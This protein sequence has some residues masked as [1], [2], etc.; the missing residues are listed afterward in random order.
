[1]RKNKAK[2]ADDEQTLRAL[3]LVAIQDESFESIRDNILEKPNRS[4]NEL[5]GDI[6]EKDTSLQMKDGSDLY[7]EMDTFSPVEHKYMEKKIRE[8]K[9]QTLLDKVCG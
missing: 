2:V 1:M 3:L 8:V 7:R 9:R 5:L 4:I 6:R